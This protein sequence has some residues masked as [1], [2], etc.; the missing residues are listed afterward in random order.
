VPAELAE[1]GGGLV[2]VAPGV[3][4]E[5]TA[6]QVVGLPVELIPPAVGVAGQ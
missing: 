2:L 3:R 4:V 5:L 1:G 6:G